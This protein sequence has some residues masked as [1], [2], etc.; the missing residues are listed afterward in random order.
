MF[1][2]IFLYVQLLKINNTDIKA[3]YIEIW[4]ISL[5]IKVNKT[6]KY[7]MLDVRE[8]NESENSYI[9]VTCTICF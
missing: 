8:R 6:N 9:K 2:I 7:D 1:T 5:W 3:Q 4:I